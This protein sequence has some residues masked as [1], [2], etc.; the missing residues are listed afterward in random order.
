MAGA[1]GAAG[2]DGDAEAFAELLRGLKERSGLSYGALAKRLHMSTSTLHRY[3]NGTATPADYA[4]V[5]RLARVCRARPEE[6]V[7]LH[8][9]WILADAARGRKAAG[10]AGAAGA[11]AAGAGAAGAGAAGAGAPTGPVPD[12]DAPNGPV[13]DEDAPNGPVPDEDAPN[14]PVADER[15]A[16]G[17]APDAP[18]A[19]LPLAEAAPAGAAGPG[20]RRAALAAAA[21]A[22]VLGTVVLAVNLPASSGGD[23]REAVSGPAAESGGA[24]TGRPDG[25]RP[26]PSGSPSPTPSGSVS[27]SP[28]PSRSPGADRPSA[29][30]SAS[31]PKPAAPEGG[32]GGGAEPQGGASVNVAVRPFVYDGPCSQHFLV[33]SEPA[34]VG[35]PAATE[36]DAPRWAAAYGAVSA[37]EQRIAV[38]LQGTGRQTVV[39]DSLQVRVV[40]KGAPPAWNDYA[41]GSGCGGQVERRSF[42]VDLDAGSPVAVPKNGQPDFPYGVTES[43]PLQF[44]VTVRTRA[45]DVR[46]DLTLKWSSGDRQGTVHIDD[47]GKPFRTSGAAGRPAYHYPLGGGEW[48]REEPQGAQVP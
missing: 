44:H 33:R 25:K 38:N 1:R 27:G 37:G 35:P 5:E 36:Q 30:A 8:R 3:C 45:H 31:E 28:S 17:G 32:S 39:L 4:P 13:P 40:S 23:G 20:R 41:M 29:S 6:L 48:I 34:Q 12:E 10:G 42:D 16:A 9:R 7:E 47:D 2:A 15:A 11:G 18:A 24:A 43:D 14:G 21:A 46:W 19:P 26:A 22:A